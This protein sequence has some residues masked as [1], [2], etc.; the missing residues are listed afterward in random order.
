MLPSMNL[1]GDTHTHT[2]T[3]KHT[4]KPFYWAA[5]SFDHSFPYDQNL[6]IDLTT[7]VMMDNRFYPDLGHSSIQL[8]HC[9]KHTHKHI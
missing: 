9:H 3:H 4:Q 8:F 7:N 6:T 2:N 1:N 5:I